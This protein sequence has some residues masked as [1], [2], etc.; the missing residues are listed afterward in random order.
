MYI[1]IYKLLMEDES[2]SL[3][4]PT[5][6]NSSEWHIKKKKA[7]S[8]PLKMMSRP[9]P[10]PPILG[11]LGSWTLQKSS[12]SKFLGIAWKGPPSIYGFKITF[13]SPF[14]KPSN[15]KNNLK[16]FFK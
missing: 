9:N 5:T 11:W 8:S 15:L 16:I 2:S 6:W 3:I 14:L 7:Y 4:N 10:T 1:F 12:F 13:G